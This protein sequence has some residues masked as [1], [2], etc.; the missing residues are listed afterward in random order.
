[1]Q[2][3]CRT[4][5]ISLHHR[6]SERGTTRGK[7]SGCS[8]QG[9]VGVSMLVQRTIIEDMGNFITEED[10]D[11]SGDKI[12]IE[13]RQTQTGKFLT[14]E[15]E[16]ESGDNGKAVIKEIEDKQTHSTEAQLH[17]EAQHASMDEEQEFDQEPL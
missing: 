2:N 14:E 8:K 7:K 1:M 13:D 10:E 11:E 3:N 16:D 5:S 12:K 6:E 4:L 17:E 15:A 9:A